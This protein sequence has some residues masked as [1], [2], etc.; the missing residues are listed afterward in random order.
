MVDDDLSIA[1]CHDIN[2]CRMAEV[3]LRESENRYRTLVSASPDAITVT[4]MEGRIEF[5]SNRALEIFG[6][7]SESEVVG[8]HILEWV[9]PEGHEKARENITYLLTNFCLRENDFVLLKKDGKKFNGEISAVPFRSAD[10]Q[11]KGI[12]FITRDVTERKRAAEA[13]MR[14]AT[15]VDQ[16]AEDIVITD[17]AGKILYV[18]PAFEATTG[19]SQS[20]AIGRNPR[21][22]KSGK[23]DDAYYQRMWAT[24]SHGEV[25]AGHLINKRKDGTL[26]EEEATISPIRNPAGK[27]VSY[28]GVRRDVTR[29]VALAAQLRQAQKMEAIGQLAGGVAHD[30]N[31]LLTA[32]H[33]NASLLLDAQLEA[34]EAVECSQEIV[35]AAE[36]AA[37][38]T[39]QL[40]MFSRKQVMQP[41]NLDL[42]EVVTQMTKMLHRIL[43]EDVALS[44]HYATHLPLIRADAGM[45]E[46][47]ILN[48]A[49]NARDAMPAGGR[50]AITTGTDTNPAAETDAANAV[51]SGTQVWLEVADQ[52]CGISPEHLGH[53]FEPFF[54]TKE[55]G[56]GTGLGLATVYA[57]VQQHQGRIEVASEVNRGT[58]FR[59]R[60]PAV[61]GVKAAKPAV[62][63]IS[64]LPRGS[65]TILLVED[66]ENVRLITRNLLQRLGYRVLEA[67]SGKAALKVWQENR[68]Q[69]R[70]LLTD[71]VMPDGVNGYDLAQRLQSQGP[72]LA[73]IFTSGYSG[74]FAGKRTTL[75]DGVNFLQKPFAPEKL[76][77]TVRKNLDRK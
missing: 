75:V 51:A 74:D 55:V 27:I 57:I 58:T 64:Q 38:L 10:G 25:W 5:V 56:K 61:S 24:L 54:T 66:A 43:G 11:P 15:A 9:A 46:Q 8:R 35:E 2:E 36:R 45:I 53:I 13:Y 50:L 32:I 76:A 72:E 49:V 67:E 77:T 34:A 48:L 39:R 44:A 21:F 19:Y 40:L 47:V 14:L 20:E 12:I 63:A 6:H 73:V 71:I 1:F 70:L 37:T 33:A 42:N 28:V 65:E 30:F 62:P 7:S 29:E 18:N 23:H 59:I 31:N 4:D 17:A 60:F 16:A 52:G 3:A 41:V 68:E 69:I 22:L 26:F